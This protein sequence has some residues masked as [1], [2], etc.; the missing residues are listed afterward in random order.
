MSSYQSRLAPVLLVSLL[1]ASAACGRS[2]RSASEAND[3][4][5]E[6]TAELL[7][8]ATLVVR[9]L[10]EADIPISRRERTRC[11]VVLPSMVS[12][13]LVIGARHGRGVVVCRAKSQ[14]GGPAFVTVTGGSAGFQAGLESSDIVM[15]IMSE[16]AVAQLFRESFTLGADASAAA[17]PVGKGAQAGTDTT[18]TAEIL[19]YARSRGLFAGAQV[20]GAVMTQ[21]HAAVHALYGDGPDVHAILAGEMPPPKEAEAFLEQVRAAFPRL[22]DDSPPPVSSNL[23]PIK[24][25]E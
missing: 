9:E 21:D 15:L 13:G 12:G 8:D 24:T 17:G 3:Q 20:S 16:R 19:S 18:M 2:P 6:R 10:A 7:R 22:A 1:C 23:L 25:S 5:R 4:D 11:V 14:W